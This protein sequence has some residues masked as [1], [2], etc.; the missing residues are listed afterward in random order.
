[1]A[2][3]TTRLPARRQPESYS[4]AAN[5]SA[6][7]CGWVRRPSGPESRKELGSWIEH[8]LSCRSPIF[9][10]RLPK[11]GEF[12]VCGADLLR[13]GHGVLDPSACQKFK[14]GRID[15]AVARYLR[16]RRHSRLWCRRVFNGYRP[17]CLNRT[18]STFHEPSPRRR[19][20]IETPY[21]LTDF[22]IGHI[23]PRQLTAYR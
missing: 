14:S 20:W 6:L 23:D 15:R 22:F 7:R 11:V 10:H 1:M 16:R 4:A 19:A 18:K 21:D 5:T 12:L 9:I 2:G 3:T 17:S 8:G 13:V